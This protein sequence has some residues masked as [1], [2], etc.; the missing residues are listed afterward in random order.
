M[1]KAFLEIDKV[2]LFL[3]PNKTILGKDV[4]QQLG[5]EV[6]A[7]G[8]KKVLVVS[9][10]GVVKAGRYAMGGLNLSSLVLEDVGFGAMKHSDASCHQAGTVLSATESQSTGFNPDELNLRVNQ[11]MKEANGIAAPAHA[12]YSVIGQATDR[13]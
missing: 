1:K 12:C 3:S 7:L 11:G 13:I 10:P 2:S 8:G 6:S 9:D 5:R 4:V